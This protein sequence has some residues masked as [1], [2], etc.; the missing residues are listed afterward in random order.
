[1]LFSA[2]KKQVY[3]LQEY[4]EFEVKSE[5]RHEYIDG[6]IILMTD[7][8]PNHNQIVG[9]LYAALNFGLKGKPY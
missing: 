5:T 3:S 8:T 7:D 9:N 4:L 2:P 6:E 1:M